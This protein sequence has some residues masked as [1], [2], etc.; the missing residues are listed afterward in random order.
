MPR[1]VITLSEHEK[2]ALISLAHREVRHPRDQVRIMVRSELERLGY[3]KSAT[4]ELLANRNE[5]HCD[6]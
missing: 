3:L 4:P 5:A 6:H 2:I 1:L